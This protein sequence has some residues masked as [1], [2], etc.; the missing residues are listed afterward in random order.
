VANNEVS[1]LIAVTMPTNF[2]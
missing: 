2:N 1:Y